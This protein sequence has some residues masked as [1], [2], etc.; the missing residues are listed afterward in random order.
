[1]S[2][3]KA[4]QVILAYEPVWAIGTGDVPSADQVMSVRIFIRKILREIYNAPVA[5]S[6]PLLYGGSTNAQNCTEFI[7]NAGMNGLLVGGAS[8]KP[9]EFV[10]MFENLVQ[11]AP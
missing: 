4:K 2:N 5:Q 6:I 7:Q 9:Q 11:V 10:G 3:A 8:L 1:M